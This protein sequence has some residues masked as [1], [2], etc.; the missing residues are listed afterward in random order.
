MQI[1]PYRADDLPE[2]VELFNVAVR[3]LGRKYYNEAQL[4][5]WAPIP[6][7][8]N[9]WADRFSTVDIRVMEEAGCPLGFVSWRKDNE[10]SGY[11]SHIFVRPDATRRGVASQLLTEAEAALSNV[12]SLH[13]HASLIAR[14]FFERHGYSVIKEELAIRNG[15][16][17]R[18]YEM[19]KDRPTA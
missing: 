3:M 19:R 18:R 14:S 17:L 1:R 11:I 13:V 5:A 10:N 6:A 4:E 16:E 15:I 8:L 7:D 2:L 9:E 12:D